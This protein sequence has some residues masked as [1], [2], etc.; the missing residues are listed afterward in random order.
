MEQQTIDRQN[1]LISISG[2]SLPIVDGLA[3][4][5]LKHALSEALDPARYSAK[6]VGGFDNKITQD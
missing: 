3:D 4:S 6:S 5:V 1:E 2:L